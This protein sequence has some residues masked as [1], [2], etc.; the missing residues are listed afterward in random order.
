MVDRDA[1]TTY[2]VDSTAGNEPDEAFDYVLSFRT[3]DEAPQEEITS[4]CF[5]MRKKD[6]TIKKKKKLEF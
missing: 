1:G 4:S 3:K 5:G 2:A 6:N